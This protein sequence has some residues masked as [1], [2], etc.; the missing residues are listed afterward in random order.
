MRMYLTR[1]H[2][3]VPVPVVNL[4][5]AA[6]RSPKSTLPPS[7]MYQL[8][9][10]QTVRLDVLGLVECGSL[11]YFLTLKAL[12]TTKFV[13]FCRLLKCLR[14]LSNKQYRLGP[15]C[16]SLHLTLLNNVSKNLQQKTN[17]DG[18]FR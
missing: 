7:P 17:A 3:T 11:E 5:L 9:F 8:K 1:V 6:P 14:N 15:H 12:F 13:C 18:I 10:S 4:E 16:L 2:N